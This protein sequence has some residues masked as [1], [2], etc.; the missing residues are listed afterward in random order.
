MLIAIW[1]GFILGMLMEKEVPAAALNRFGNAD[2][3][4][5][6][7]KDHHVRGLKFSLIRY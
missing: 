1:F 5:W 3:C 4:T 7:R 2:A 6:Y